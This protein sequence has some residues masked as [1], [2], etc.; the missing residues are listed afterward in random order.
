MIMS[1]RRAIDG[2]SIDLT[3]SH[4]EAEHFHR[5]GWVEVS[6]EEIDGR[7]GFGDVKRVRIDVGQ[8]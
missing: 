5:E 1:L 7:S 8:G 3:L 6:A 4:N 2:A